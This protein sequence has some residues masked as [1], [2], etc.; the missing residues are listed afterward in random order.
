MSSASFA[1]RSA[2]IPSNVDGCSHPP[3]APRSAAHVG[4]PRTG[5]GDTWPAIAV[6]P[7]V[8]KQEQVLTAHALDARRRDRARDRH[9]EVDSA[10]LDRARVQQVEALTGCVEFD[11]GR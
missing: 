10:T 7:D 2:V 1:T 6:L 5:I 4:P 8:M 3:F 9:H 11:F